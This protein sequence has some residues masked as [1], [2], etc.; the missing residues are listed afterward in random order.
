MAGCAAL[1][2]ALIGMLYLTSPHR[3]ERPLLRAPLAAA[4]KA[5]PEG[6]APTRAVGVRRFVTAEGKS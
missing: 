2:G 5:P 4:K 1:A 3:A 6:G